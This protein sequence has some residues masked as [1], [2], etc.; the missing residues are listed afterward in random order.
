MIDDLTA[1]SIERMKIE[2]FEPAVIVETSPN[3]FQAWLNHGRSSKPQ[4][5]R[6]RRSYSPSASVA[7]RRA[8]TGGI[9]GGWRDSPTRSPSDCYHQ[10]C[11]LSR[12]FGQR[13]GES[14][15]NPPCSVPV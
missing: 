3:N 5:V 2:G 4:K 13:R 10:E 8:R 9:S 12:G 1:E 15:R 7:I 6:E 14:I 11:G